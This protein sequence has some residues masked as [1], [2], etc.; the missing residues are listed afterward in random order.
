MFALEIGECLLELFQVAVF[1]LSKCALRFAVLLAA[2]LG[3]VSQMLARVFDRG[4]KD[5]R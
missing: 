4:G 3:R 2:A 1:A 5:L